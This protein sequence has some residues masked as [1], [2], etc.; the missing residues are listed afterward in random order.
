MLG[1]R[2]QPT[3]AEVIGYLLYLI[4]AALYVLWP[5]QVGS[6]VARTAG[7]T[8]LLLVVVL[9]LA[10]CGTGGGSGSSGGAKQVKVKLTD[11]GCSPAS[12]EQPRASA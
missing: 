7:T 9:A 5:A 3:Q 6:R 12:L 2:P 4:P 8:T 10:A 1:W 11:A